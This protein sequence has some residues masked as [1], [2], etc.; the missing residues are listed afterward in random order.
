[1]AKI[2]I[3]N[4]NFRYEEDSPLILQGIDLKVNEGEFVCLLGL[5]GSG[6]STLL[7]LIAGLQKPTDGEI[8]IDNTIVK[9]ASLSKSVVFQN[10]GLFPWMTAGQNI[11]LALEQRFPN[12][13]DKENVEIAKSFIKMVELKESV[14]NKLPKELSGGMMQRCAIA[15]SFSINPPILL[16]DEPFGALDAVTRATLQ[17]LLLK[18]WSQE[19]NRKNIFFVTHDVNE[20]IKLATRIIVLGQQPANIIYDV[21]VP[22]DLIAESRDLFEKNEVKVLREDLLYYINRDIDSSIQDSEK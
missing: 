3:N 4:I 15:R 17:E 20:A 9:E 21:K 7:R 22:E 1:M 14:F 19:E 12:N 18:L 10:Y 16:M 2:E 6:K 13:T 8:I 5:S 11:T